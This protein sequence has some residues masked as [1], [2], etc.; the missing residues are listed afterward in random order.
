MVPGNRG[1]GR[2]SGRRAA[3]WPVPGRAGK[4]GSP[5]EES[6]RVALQ[7][8]QQLSDKGLQ[9]GVGLVDPEAGKGSG[10][11]PQTLTRAFCLF[12]GCP[13]THI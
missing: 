12:C 6:Q 7:N 11:R 1:E 4:V 3:S 2:E 13:H 8:D 5:P 9:A 10:L